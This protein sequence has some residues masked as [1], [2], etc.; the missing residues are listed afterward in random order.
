MCRRITYDVAAGTACDTTPTN[1]DITPPATRN[2]EGLYRR[3]ACEVE[4]ESTSQG[5]RCLRLT[6]PL[7]PATSVLISEWY[8]RQYRQVYRR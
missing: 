6:W 4:L 2:L 5:C 7:L 8:R 1:E 3:P